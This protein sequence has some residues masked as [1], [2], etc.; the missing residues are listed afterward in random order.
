[1]SVGLV[2]I[3]LLS[4][5]VTVEEGYYPL[6]LQSVGLL[7]LGLMSG[8]A[9]IC[10]ATVL[11][12]YCLSGLCPQADVR[13][14]TVWESSRLAVSSF[15]FQPIPIFSCQLF[16]RTFIFRTNLGSARQK[17]ALFIKFIN[18][19]ITVVLLSFPL[20]F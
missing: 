15:N 9:V 20:L 18:I 10:W 5:R 19:I 12:G 2:T 16:V 13:R 14:A 1:M 11:S 4:G 17:F 6:G 7:S 8:R 3:G